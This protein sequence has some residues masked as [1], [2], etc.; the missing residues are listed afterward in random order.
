MTRRNAKAT[1]PTSR[2]YSSS[3]QVTPR[4][5]TR[6]SSIPENGSPQWVSGHAS[7]F[8]TPE[9][10]SP[11]R[12]RR[13][14]MLLSKEDTT[15][16]EMTQ[17]RRNTMSQND[18]KVPSWFISPPGVKTRSRR[19]SI[20]VSKPKIESTR[21]PSSKPVPL[22][23]QKPKASVKRAGRQVGAKKDHVNLKA[24]ITLTDIS[25][26]DTRKKY[27]LPSETESVQLETSSLIKTKKSTKRH[28]SSDE[29]C[30]SD[31]L[32][33]SKVQRLSI[34]KEPEK[35]IPSR[36]Y[37]EVENEKGIEHIE[38]N[39]NINK[40]TSQEI[41]DN[42]ITTKISD[43][44]K[45]NQLDENITEVN[46][47]KISSPDLVQPQEILSRSRASI[48]R[49]SGAK[50][51]AI[52]EDTQESQIIKPIFDISTPQQEA[53]ISV[54]NRALN[55]IET[56]SESVTSSRKKTNKKSTSHRSSM[57]NSQENIP[58]KTPSSIS[59]SSN[60]VKA[61]SI[62]IKESNTQKKIIK[63]IF[64]T[65]NS[66]KSPAEKELKESDPSIILN[67]ESIIDDSQQNKESA[68][69]EFL[70]PANTNSKISELFTP[71]NNPNI[72]TF[73]K[74][75]VQKHI[76][77]MRLE[78]D[79]SVSL[80]DML[81]SDKEGVGQST[82]S[83]EKRDS[84][85]VTGETEDRINEA[86][87]SK[88]D[89]DQEGI[90]ES[91]DNVKTVEKTNSQTLTDETEN[92]VNEDNST[93]QMQDINQVDLETEKDV[94]TEEQL[95]ESCPNQSVNEIDESFGYSSHSLKCTIL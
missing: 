44:L 52:T 94:E 53:N 61:N 31:Q 9:T 63:S 13:T 32:N 68:Q 38:I 4:R 67:T 92:L 30:E 26:D 8:K 74:S 78:L 49:K 85:S 83:V 91:A 1:L 90:T 70:S 54:K 24:A 36:H 71:L 93:K 77:L 82:D 29:I 20:Q 34:S 6:T 64:D 79:D 55:K 45:S 76:P 50:S 16:K 66:I 89:L 84:L 18:L 28:S 22:K 17:S 73:L 51:I 43:S 35:T 69:L 2:F 40:Q 56:N 41:I 48:K 81:S 80:E 27:T 87:S 57:I 75:S 15:S 65:P 25:Y 21:L 42:A 14:T 88:Q 33:F 72:S 95:L 86:P 58:I 19:S 3:L 12:R 37:P 59:R 60:R 10:V 47:N 23:A 62:N 7:L 39:V 46:V 11:Q 5:S